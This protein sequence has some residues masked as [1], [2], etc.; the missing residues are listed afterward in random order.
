[1]TGE[2]GPTGLT[3]VLGLIQCSSVEMCGRAAGSRWT[4]TQKMTADGP[5]AVIECLEGYQLTSSSE[6]QCTPTDLLLPLD[7]PCVPRGC[8]HWGDHVPHG[9]TISVICLGF[10]FE[11]TCHYGTLQPT[12]LLCCRTPPEINNG[13]HQSLRHSN[14]ITTVYSCDSGYDLFG[15]SSFTCQ[16]ESGEWSPPPRGGILH[17]KPI[18]CL[19]PP[20]VPHGKFYSPSSSTGNFKEG[21][22]LYLRCFISQQTHICDVMGCRFIPERLTCSKQIQCRH[23]CDHYEVPNGQAFCASN[24]EGEKCDITCNRLYNLEVSSQIQCTSS[25]WS[26]FPYCIG[27]RTSTW[28]LFFFY[29]ST[30]KGLEI[31]SILYKKRQLLLLSFSPQFGIARY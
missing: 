16:V 22:S 13:H 31:Q 28:L 20:Q 6:I 30:Y 7:R 14:S 25:G 21:D 17:C 26:S 10:L 15:V 19:A 27:E 29:L 3:G 1:S 2:V 4:C 23:S 12:P 11:S 9:R 8:I 18:P 24:F 5:V